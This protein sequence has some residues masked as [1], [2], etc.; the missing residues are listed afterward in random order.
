M[1]PQEFQIPTGKY[2]ESITDVYENANT[3]NDTETNTTNSNCVSY[4]EVKARR[5]AIAAAEC[6]ENKEVIVLDGQV[7]ALNVGKSLDFLRHDELLENIGFP[8]KF[9]NL[10]IAA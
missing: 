5:E 2:P 1:S 8:S 3:E 9:E 7:I 4:D 10:D 6:V